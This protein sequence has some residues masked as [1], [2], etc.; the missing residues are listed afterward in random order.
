MK[1]FA[2]ETDFELIG[3]KM[4]KFGIFGDSMY[5]VVQSQEFSIDFDEQKNEMFNLAVALRLT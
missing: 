1:L 3:S 5:W 2:F 4:E